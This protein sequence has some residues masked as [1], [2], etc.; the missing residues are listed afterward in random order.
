MTNQSAP[1]GQPDKPVPTKRKRLWIRW[2]LAMA[3]VAVLLAIGL[4]IA[5]PAVLS[6][7]MVRSWILEKIR[8]QV[9]S[10]VELD[11]LTFSW[12][13]GF[14]IEG[15]RIGNPPG[16]P[17]G[18]AVRV[19]R[20]VAGLSYL[21]FVR[22]GIKCQLLVENPKIAVRVLPGDRINLN[23]IVPRRTVFRPERDPEPQVPP[24]AP[25][26]RE[27]FDLQILVRLRGGIVEI[28]DEVRGIRQELRDLRID[29]RNGSLGAPIRL[30][31]G[32]R[33]VRPGAP[34]GTLAMSAVIDPNRGMP[35]RSCRFETSGIDLAAY[36]PIV[37]T[38]LP[39]KRFEAFRGRIAGHL[40]AEPTETADEIEVV[41]DL[42]IRDLDI[43]GGPLPPGKGFAAASWM[44]TPHARVNYETGSGRLVGTQMD[45]G[46][47]KL[48][49]LPEQETR[50]LFA[51]PITG[52]APLGLALAVDLAQLAEQPIL[53]PG[54]WRGSIR[55]AAGVFLGSSSE[56]PRTFAMKLGASGLQLP[57]SLLP[58]GGRVPERLS[59]VTHGTFQGGDS[60]H[61]KG[62]YEGRTT[63]VACKGTYEVARDYRADLDLRVDAAETAAFVAPFLPDG[64]KLEGATELAL[65]ATGT[66][67][68]ENGDRRAT[69]DLSVRGEFK[70]PAVAWLGNSLA[71]V[72][73]K[74][75]LENGVLHVE[76]SGEGRLNGGPLSL[77]LSLAGL[78]TGG[79]EGDPRLR[80]E[81]SWRD[82]K[83]AYGL[84][85]VLQYGLPLLAGLPTNDLSR[86]GSIDFQAM[87]GLSLEGGGPLPAGADDLLAQ[88]AKW[89]AKGTLLLRDG[90]FQPST[91]LGP[92]LELFKKNRIRFDDVKSQV[93]IAKGD[94]RLKD[95]T[96]GGKDGTVT[97]GGKTSLAGEL[98]VR[99][100][101]TD[102][103]ARHRD[104]QRVL[105]HLAGGKLMLD[106]GG[107]L[108]APEIA[109][110]DV[111][112]KLLQ[113]GIQGALEGFL[114]GLGSGKKPKDALQELLRGLG[115]KKK[116][117][118]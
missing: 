82:G 44:L 112:Q 56:T 115:G 79:K 21:G 74:I 100:D 27:P 84:T 110:E 2:L 24:R 25:E 69:P 75:R 6:S 58:P 43:R 57:S 63:G 80:F 106:I 36:E 3:A 40:T 95:F 118:Q 17:P 29:A 31:V 9:R 98:E 64:M 53:P 65:V 73:Q 71:G 42:A 92:I 34:E 87:A 113:Q 41:G 107:T 54:Q 67:A 66:R 105:G 93:T 32:S 28:H 99:V 76:P 61:V 15:L 16:F 8:P 94:V 11:R 101:F 109:V 108:W 85:P 51:D 13:R 52:Q 104:G 89:D 91:A 23:E 14:T 22:G 12:G 77:S 88:L 37:A 97:I 117:Q 19:E 46:F 90:S 30:A 72:G 1:A 83:A 96:M 39:E 59:I 111:V 10:Q 47:A 81:L 4:A 26:P 114:K 18:D 55:L 33:L 20:A 102:W 103:L 35:L 78:G 48:V 60:F 86:I 45:L 38:F 68:Q 5:I 50:G 7:D 49:A 62:D 116:K 70:A